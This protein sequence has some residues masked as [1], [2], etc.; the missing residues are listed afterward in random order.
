MAPLRFYKTTDNRRVVVHRTFGNETPT[1][2]CAFQL[3]EVLVV[4]DGGRDRRPAGDPD[5]ATREEPACLLAAGGE[6]CRVSL[7]SVRPAT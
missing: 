7:A 6:P 2:R 1:M 3:D 4:T 5:C